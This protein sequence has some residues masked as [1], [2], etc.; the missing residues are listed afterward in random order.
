MQ[1][2]VTL[3]LLFF[4]SVGKTLVPL[5]NVALSDESHLDYGLSFV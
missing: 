4:I 3:F 5:Y 1:Q 2:V